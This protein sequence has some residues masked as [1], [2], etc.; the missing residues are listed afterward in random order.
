MPVYE[1]SPDN[2]VGYVTVRD[3]LALFWERSLVVLEDAIRPVYAVP[4]T[5]KAVTLLNEMRRRRIQLAVVV[6]DAGAM[7][8]IVTLED[9]FEELVGDV[10][11]EHDVD[12][13]PSIRREADGCALVRA[14]VAVRE[15]NRALGVDLPEGERWSTIAGLCLEIAGHIPQAGERLV[16]SDGSELEIVEATTRQVR[17]VRVCAPKAPKEAD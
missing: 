15:V 12:G 8:G 6:D 5:S 4:E 10:F 13:E 2:I 14:D 7:L 1:G 17:T 11:S 3:L 16:A 9:L